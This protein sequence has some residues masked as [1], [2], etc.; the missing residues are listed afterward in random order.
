MRAGINENRSNIKD[1]VPFFA[2]A[3]AIVF[4]RTKPFGGAARPSLGISDIQMDTRSCF[5]MD[6][7]YARRN[8][9]LSE[10]W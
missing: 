1:G 8:P 2:L 7:R 4:S 6:R 10:T 5:R 3:G 9:A